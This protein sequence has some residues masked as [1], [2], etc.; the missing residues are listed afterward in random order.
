MP[1]AYTPSQRSAIA[2][3]T[4][5]T[6][7]KESVAAKSRQ[8]TG[9]YICKGSPGLKVR[10]SLEIPTVALKDMANASEMKQPSQKGKELE[11]DGW[12]RSQRELVVVTQGGYVVSRNE[13]DHPLDEELAN[14]QML[15]EYLPEYCQDALE[16][17]PV[18]Q[19]FWEGK[20]MIEVLSAVKKPIDRVWVREWLEEQRRL[21]HVCIKEKFTDW[22]AKADDPSHWITWRKLPL[23]FRYRIHRLAMPRKKFLKM[24]KFYGIDPWFEDHHDQEKGTLKRKWD[25]DKVPTLRLKLGIRTRLQAIHKDVMTSVIPFED[26]PSRFRAELGMPN[27]SDRELSMKLHENEVPADCYFGVEVTAS[28]TEPRLSANVVDIIQNFEA[29]LP[30]APEPSD[31]FRN[32]SLS[33]PDPPDKVDTK[34][35]LGLS[36]SSRASRKLGAKV[37]L[38]GVRE[39]QKATLNTRIPW[40]KENVQPSPLKGYVHATPSALDQSKGPRSNA[41]GSDGEA[42]QE[43]R[44]LAGMTITTASSLQQTKGGCSTPAVDYLSEDESADDT[45]SINPATLGAW[46]KRRIPANNGHF[47]TSF[48]Q[49]QSAS[50]GKSGSS[51][52]SN[53]HKLFDRYRGTIDDPKESPHTIEVDGTIKYLGD[54]G[55]N[56]DEVAVLAILTEL[57]APIMG[58]LSRESFVSYWLFHNADSLSKQQAHMATLRHNLANDQSF[59]KRVY[60]HTFVLARSPG[61]KAVQLDAAIEYWRLLFQRPSMSWNTSTTPWLNWWIEYLETKWKRSVNRD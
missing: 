39:I 31:T 60:K 49:V 26:A 42:I 22:M 24:L 15:I 1:P 56:L 20:R 11:E 41:F 48:F 27:I 19:R 61:Q 52:A 44:R 43:L 16:K 4:S 37:G 6:S 58:E 12:T 34:D 25:A 55:V 54:L 9:S 18:H 2:Q 17:M 10:P 46:R 40:D 51:L 57:N 38:P 36:M 5:V 21:Y 8:F 47:Y 7:A 35:L 29:S 59:F 50:S 23:M 13:K 53:V 45:V 33:T 30:S 14:Y 32:L 28:A 3:F